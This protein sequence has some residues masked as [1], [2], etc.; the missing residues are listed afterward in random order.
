MVNLPHPEG[1][2]AMLSGSAE[3][4]SQFTSMPF[5]NQAL[6]VPG[7]RIVLNSYDIMGGPNTA[8]M[9]WTT[10]KFR[11]ENPRA[12]RPS[13]TPC[14]R[15]RTSSTPTGAAPPNCTRAE[16]GGKEN[17]DKIFALISDPGVRYTM[18]PSGCCRSRSS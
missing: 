17:A 10:K 5:Q 8:L 14:G 13:S 9:V 6:E 15:P 7:T 4:Q 11:D 1:L 18:A 3:I 16:S 2:R 12:T